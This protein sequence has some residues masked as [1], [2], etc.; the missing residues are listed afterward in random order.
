MIKDNTGCTRCLKLNSEEI[1]AIE[2]MEGKDNYTCT[3]CKEND[4][5]TCPSPVYTQSITNNV[6]VTRKFQSGA[7]AILEEELI[8]TC[9]TCNLPIQT[10]LV[11]YTVCNQPNHEECSIYEQYEHICSNCKFETIR[12]QNEDETLLKVTISQET[13]ELNSI[14]TD[15]IERQSLDSSI[16]ES[17]RKQRRINQT[18]ET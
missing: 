15:N 17:E 14:N 7:Q 9:N 16:A 5:R 6:I 18:T 11:R 8:N 3:L 13:V 12:N 10:Q 2:N 4:K 1:S